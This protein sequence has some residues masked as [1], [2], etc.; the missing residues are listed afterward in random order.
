METENPLCYEIIMSTQ[1]LRWS[2][3]HKNKDILS[4]EKKQDTE[5]DVF[6]VPLGRERR[7]KK[8]THI[9]LYLH[10]EM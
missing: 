3:F 4:S 6:I 1:I 5:N 7:D 10:K 2:H 9:C 8:N